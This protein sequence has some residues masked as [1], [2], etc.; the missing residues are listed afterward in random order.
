MRF[1]AD[2]NFPRPAV[3]LLRSLGHDVRWARAGSPGLKDHALLERAEAESRL[4][5]TLDK[6]FWQLAL[7]RPSPLKRS[8][9][10]L[11]TAPAEN[12]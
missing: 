6:D 10:E 3:E 12:N 5:L 2:E 11:F 7:R 4:L 8:G 1:L 9:V